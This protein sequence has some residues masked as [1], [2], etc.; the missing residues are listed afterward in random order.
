LLP[1]LLQDLPLCLQLLYTLL[2]L[3]QMVSKRPCAA[4]GCS[5]LLL[6]CL[7]AG[8]HLLQ[9]LQ[10][11]ARA[12]A[13]ILVCADVTGESVP[14]NNGLKPSGW[15]K[16]C[17][18]LSV[19]AS[20]QCWDTV[21]RIAFELAPL[22]PADAAYLIWDACLFTVSSSSSKASEDIL[23]APIGAPCVAALQCG[24]LIRLC[25]KAVKGGWLLICGMRMLANH[26]TNMY[27]IY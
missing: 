2:H 15:Q 16:K 20:V 22:L 19:V 7:Q 26:S 12:I 24:C 21:Q 11:L 18:K 5:M 6:Q 1:L 10:L 27:L 23:S 4:A 13:A 8:L 9:L 14:R 25:Q 17:C 3:V